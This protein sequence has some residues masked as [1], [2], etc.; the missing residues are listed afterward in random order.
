VPAG[1]GVVL[2]TRC[3]RPIVHNPA[4]FPAVPRICMQCGGIEPLPFSA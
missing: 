1:G 2:C 3:Q 4:T